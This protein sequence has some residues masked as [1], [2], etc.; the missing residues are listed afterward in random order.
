MT[1]KE[2]KNI[3]KILQTQQKK[4]CYNY[5]FIVHSLINSFICLKQKCITSFFLSPLP[6]CH[7][8]LL[9]RVGGAEHAL[10]V[11]SCGLDGRTDV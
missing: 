9:F 3:Y 6:K 2:R 10:S 1:V 4:I 5:M 8:L 11:F 7:H